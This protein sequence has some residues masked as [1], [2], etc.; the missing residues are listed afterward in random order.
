MRKRQ[1][2]ALALAVLT[3]L[4]L[5]GCGAK[6]DEDK[7][8]H[9]AISIYPAKLTA[10]ETALTEL[11]DI[12][13][14][15]Y[16]MFDFQMGSDTE[17]VQS[18]ML[19][20]YELENGKWIDIATEARPFSD[21]AGRIAL[22][23]GKMPEGVKTAIQSESG[24]DSNSFVPVAEGDVSAM[25]YATSVLTDSPS[26]EFDEEVPLVLQIATSKSEFSTCSV[27]YFGMPRELAKHDYDHVYAI[28]VT[29]S[30]KSVS[31]IVQS[32]APGIPDDPSAEP[33]PE[34]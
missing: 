17:G 10:E 18:I 6:D 9:A 14:N 16:R 29:F 4:A 1:I 15:N 33:S 23:F 27:D 7:T 5:C 19:R 11:L 32:I 8:G 2:A 24:T 20:V 31:D 28:T 30:Q 22:T 26:V 21:A 12:G 34:N 25:T 3:A 13:M